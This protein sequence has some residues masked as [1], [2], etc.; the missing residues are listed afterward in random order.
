MGD[1]AAISQ[2]V[3]DHVRLFHLRL[4]PLDFLDLVAVLSDRGA[5]FHAH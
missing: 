5:E 4:L 1:L 3:G 2:Y